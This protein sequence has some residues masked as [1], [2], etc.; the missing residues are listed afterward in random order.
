VFNAFR[1]ADGRLPPAPTPALATGQV[2]LGSFNHPAKLSNG[3]LDAWGAIL[4]G[5]PAARL[6]L[7]YSYFADP[8]L[9]RVTQARLAAR[10]VAPERVVFAGHTRGA[11]YFRAFREVDLMLD[12][13]PAPGST[14][15][16]EALSNGVPVL[17]KPTPTSGGRCVRAILL[18]AG[19]PD[20]IAESPDDYV[21]RAVALAN[22][23][24]GLDALR[25][26]VRPGFDDG[27][28]CDEAGFTRRVEATFAEMF[29]LWRA[30]KD[31]E[32]HG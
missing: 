2:T 29:D 10:G 14:T 17:A 15:T 28:C 12:V 24:H 16:L 4:R 3:V 20:M 26:R 23:P 19:L 13:W 1:P 30:R 21:A 5:A 27:P 11:D 8:V 22:D 32:A 18:G 9:C 6:L 7:K 31:G 25:S